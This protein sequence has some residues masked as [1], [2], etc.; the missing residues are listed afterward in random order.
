MVHAILLQKYYS[1]NMSGIS[2]T[3]QSWQDIPL[4]KWCTA[5]ILLCAASAS[6]SLPVQLWSS[7]SGSWSGYMY[8]I[9][10]QDLYE[11]QFRYSIPVCVHPIYL[12]FL[13]SVDSILAIVH[14][15][16]HIPQD[17][18]W[19]LITQCCFECSTQYYNYACCA[20][21]LSTKSWYT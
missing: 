10:A 17:Y 7:W 13:L 15:A 2:E 6:K 11:N 18:V 21:S 16:F 5:L 9:F 4:R 8:M 20:V 19:W 14:H 12:W 3:F 1:M